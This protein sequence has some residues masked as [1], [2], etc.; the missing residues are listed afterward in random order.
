LLNWPG[1]GCAPRSA[2]L[3][4]AFSGTSPTTTFLLRTMLAR[5]DEASADLAA[6]EAK[7]A[8]LI[9]PFDQAVDRLDEIPRSRTD[10]GARDDR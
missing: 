8:E 10:R 2:Y 5:I 3:E 1:L 9:A 4:E 6:V 7:V